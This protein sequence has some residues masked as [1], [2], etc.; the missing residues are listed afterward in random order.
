M[1]TTT[2]MLLSSALLEYVN[3]IPQWTYTVESI[4]ALGKN[5]MTLADDKT[6]TKDED[7][8]AKEVQVGI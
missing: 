1:K 5:C 7:G 8:I 2:L 4:A 3:S 6:T